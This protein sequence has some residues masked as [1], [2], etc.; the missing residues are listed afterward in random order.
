MISEDLGWTL[1]SLPAVH[2]LFSA[3]PGQCSAGYKYRGTRPVCLSSAPA[4][5]ESRSHHSQ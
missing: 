1:P 5:R 3:G 4:S 2:L